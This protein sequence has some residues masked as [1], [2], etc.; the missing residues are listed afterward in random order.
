LKFSLT[1][2]TEERIFLRLLRLNPSIRA[3]VFTEKAIRALF[4]VDSKVAIPGKGLFRASIDTIFR[5]TGKTEMDSLLFGP[6]GMD[7]N[8]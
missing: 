5:F 6:V 4:F 1:G 2:V 8:S 7:A 3:G